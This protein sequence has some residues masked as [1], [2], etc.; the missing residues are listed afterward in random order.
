MRAFFLLCLGL[1][2]CNA[3]AA[4]WAPGSNFKDCPD[5]PE[6]VVVP[7][8]S[9]EMGSDDGPRERPIHKVNIAYSFAVGKYNVTFA[10]W[11]ACVADGG[12]SG[13]RP[14]E[15]GLG[16]K[17]VPVFYVSWY[18]AQTYITWL[19][20]KAGAHYRLLSEAE[21]EYVARAGTTTTYWWGTDLGVGNANCKG[22]GEG[23]TPIPLPSGSFKPNPFGLYDTAGNMSTWI[24][25]FW[26]KD[27]SGAP[28]DGK[29][30]ETGDQRRRVW[31][32]GY[33][34]Y[35]ER[36]MHV[37]FRNGD[38]P[39]VRNWRIGFRVARDLEPSK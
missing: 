17:N 32:N 20:R 36:A 26:N 19:N 1:C 13:Y 18:D 24:E 11:D 27:Y 33:W 39:S 2:A 6:M 7:P 10:E 25:D 22:C 21:W 34:D 4:D 15:M 38:A 29:A 30:W 14:D 37:S 35:G 23:S 5:C 28:T 9:F 12:C 8:G 3:C 31:R 16:R